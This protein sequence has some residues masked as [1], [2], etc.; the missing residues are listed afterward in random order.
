MDWLSGLKSY[1]GKAAGGYLSRHFKAKAENAVRKAQNKNAAVTAAHNQGILSRHKAQVR[2]EAVSTRVRIQQARNKAVGAQR[3]ANAF[4]GVSGGSVDAAEF[5]VVRSAAMKTFQTQRMA[6]Q[7]LVNN[8]E[9]VDQNK[10]NAT[11]GQKTML[12]GPSLVM[13]MLGMA[14]EIKESGMEGSDGITDE[15][16][17]PH[18]PLNIL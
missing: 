4:S 10:V 9:A 1:D 11:L 12:A 18:N 3:V 16:G 6:E 8:A 17:E 5:D 13:T 7:E 14:A 15:V 2:E